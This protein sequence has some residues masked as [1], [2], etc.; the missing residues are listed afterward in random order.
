MSKRRISAET[1]G[2]SQRTK[3]NS[4]VISGI[5]AVPLI[6]LHQLHPCLPF[7]RAMILSISSGADGILSESFLQG[8][9]GHDQIIV[10]DSDA[11][12][13]SLDVDAGL[14]GEDFARF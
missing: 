6:S 11:E 3:S 4:S 14:D 9:V 13:L 1:R 12:F 7:P 8:V 2:R 10:F 5:L